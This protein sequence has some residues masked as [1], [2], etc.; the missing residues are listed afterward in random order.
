MK[1]VATIGM[2]GDVASVI[3]GDRVEVY[4]MIGPGIDPHAYKAKAGDVERLNNAD[5]ILYNGLHLEAKMGEI[6][7]RISSTHNTVAVSETFREDELIEVKEGVHDPHVWFDVEKWQVVTR[8]ILNALKDTDAAGAENYDENFETYLRE[9]EELQEFVVEQTGRVPERNRVLITAHDAFNYF[10]EAYGFE[11]RGLQ[12]IST[13]DEAGTGDVRNLAD[14]IAEREISAIFVET[15]VSTKSIQA[16]QEAVRDR[17]FEVTIGGELFSD[18]MGSPGTPEGT[19]LGMV[20]HNTE[21]IVEAL[22]AET[23]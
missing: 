10:G 9:L 7:E 3:G 14:F 8:N 6:L 22:L 4:T 21:T 16:L 1:I 5:L 17:G 2:I 12:G 23:E 13:V 20:R 15:S 19:Y 18:A 11:V